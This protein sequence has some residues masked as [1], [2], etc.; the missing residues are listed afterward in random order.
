MKSKYSTCASFE[1]LTAQY[2]RL[3]LAAFQP[4]SVCTVCVHVCAVF[5]WLYLCTRLLFYDFQ[6][7]LF[8]SLT[9]LG[10]CSRLPDI[11]TWLAV[12]KL[13]ITTTKINSRHWPGPRAATTSSFLPVSL[14]ALPFLFLFFASR[15]LSLMC[16][17]VCVSSVWGWSH[18]TNYGESNSVKVY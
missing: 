4:P 14:F 10:T 2:R 17:C 12:F 11:Y 15:V 16:L 7:W 9:L 6:S 5:L 8:S 13:N 18:A 1:T 3:K